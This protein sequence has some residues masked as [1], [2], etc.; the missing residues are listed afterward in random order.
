MADEQKGGSGKLFVFIIILLLIGGTGY[1]LYQ[2]GTFNGAG[3]SRG[4]SS[5]GVRIIQ[6]ESQGSDTSP[7]SDESKPYQPGED[8]DS[9]ETSIKDLKPRPPQYIP[10]NN[11]AQQEPGGK[12][13]QQKTENQQKGNSWTDYLP[14]LVILLIIITGW[15]V[16]KHFRKPKQGKTVP[17]I[18][19]II[20]DGQT[21]V[22][23]KFK[24]NRLWREKEIKIGKYVAIIDEITK[25][26]YH[27]IIEQVAKKEGKSAKD[28]EYTLRDIFISN[29]NSNKDVFKT[30]MEQFRFNAVQIKD[31]LE[32]VQEKIKG[33]LQDRMDIK[34]FR[35]LFLASL[36]GVQSQRDDLAQEQEKMITE[37]SAA[38]VKV[39]ED[40][41]KTNKKI[42]DILRNL[43]KRQ[44]DAEKVVKAHL[45]QEDKEIHALWKELRGNNRQA[46][47]E[48][49]LE[50]VRTLVK[51][52]HRADQELHQLIVDTTYVSHLQH[53][54][55]KFLS[56]EEED[57][58]S[59]QKFFE[60]QKGE[61][62]SSEELEKQI[63]N[64]ERW[65]R[66]YYRENKEGSFSENKET[67][68]SLI[69]VLEYSGTLGERFG[70]E[71]LAIKDL[72]KKTEQENIQAPAN[73]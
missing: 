14:Y 29:R 48:E 4:P 15:R 2:K 55:E 32:P 65:F 21:L 62:L 24:D 37:T 20:D 28:A 35:A 40:L 9:I 68:A 10:Q 5:G 43:G 49:L 23:K 27:T 63:H 42:I 73:S 61:Q 7:S 1:Y 36:R 56:K 19:Q 26:T 67:K 52:E 18:D 51:E 54:F 3:E 34:T 39:L 58:Q 8:L 41:D 44:E 64:S 30:N 12:T 60:V 47:N 33:Q 69:H 13:E 38:L 57:V 72:E 66:F 16:W 31:V 22:T 25:K 50:K 11:P 71:L 59:A 70:K 6:P 53:A 46:K 17:P 45:K